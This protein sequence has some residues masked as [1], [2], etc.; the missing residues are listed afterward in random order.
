MHCLKGADSILPRH[1]SGIEKDW[2][3]EGLSRLKQKSIEIH[4]VW[5]SVGRPGQGPIHQERIQIRASYRSALRA[6]QCAPKQKTWD[7][8]HSAMEYSDT[9]EFWNSWKSLY[10]K[11]NNHFSPV[12]NGCS[13]KQSIAEEFRK[14][15]LENSRPNKA[16]EVDE[17]NSNF[18][19]QY[20]EFGMKH[21]STCDCTKFKVTAETVID[22][23]CRMKKG[24]CADDDGLAPEHFH[25]APFCLVQKLVL[26]FNRMLIHSYVPSQFRF[27]FMIPLIKDNQGNH[28]DLAN[29]RGIT[30]SPIISKVFE[31]SLKI[32]FSPYLPTSS[33]QFGFK[34]KSSTVHALHCLR[35]TVEYFTNNDSRVYCS[36]LDASKAFDRVIHSGLFIKLMNKNV[37]KLFLDIVLTWHNGLYCR[38][39]WDGHFSE[40]FHVSAGVRQGGVLSPDLYCLY[41]DDLISILKSLGVG[42]HVRETFA[43]ALFYADDMAVLAPSLHGLQKLLNACSAYCTAWDIKLNAKKTKNIVFGKGCAPSHQV[44]LDGS[45]LTWESECVYLG[46]T[47]KSGASFGCCVKDKLSKFYRA[48]NAIIRIEGRSDDM[49]MLR[50]L[51]AHCLPVLAYGAEVIHVTNRDDRRQMRVAYNAIY[52]KLFGYS[53]RESVTLLQHA[54]GRPTWE[55]FLDNRRASFLRRCKQCPSDSVINAFV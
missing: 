11:N 29:Y 10:S 33:Y 13:S 50:L 55:E 25:N 47:L 53:Y 46:V 36:F 8:I 18:A 44:T 14:S 31:H 9:N 5:I 43:A 38:V 28:S 15:F 42:C 16:S 2:W 23:I 45:K 20:Q 26:L 54:L 49:V 39:R 22:A 12:V 41:V 40:W 19:S 17:M 48:L 3:T 30:I 7:K 35:E 21:S 24:K 1:K 51:E 6:A 52:R 4:R 34:R 32:I 27:G 37:P